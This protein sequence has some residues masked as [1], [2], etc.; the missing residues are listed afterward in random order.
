MRVHHRLALGVGEFGVGDAQHVHLDARGDQRDHRMHVLRNAGR[1]V[2]RDRGP[3]RVDILL[4]YAV[5]AQEVSRG[6]GAVDL[7]ALVGAAVPMRQPHVVEHRAGIEQLG[8]ERQAAPRAGQRSP[9]ED[10]AGM[11]EQQR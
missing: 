2:Q 9:V 1:G 8:I 10:A 11:V 3:H 6:V 4:R 5:A 7:E